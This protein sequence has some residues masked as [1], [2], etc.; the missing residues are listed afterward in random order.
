MGKKALRETRKVGKALREARISGRAD[1]SDFKRQILELRAKVRSSLL[2]NDLLAMP[3]IPEKRIIKRNCKG[4][5]VCCLED[6]G[7]VMLFPDDIE[8]IE[9]RVANSIGLRTV[10]EKRCEVDKLTGNGVEIDRMKWKG[11]CAFLEPSGNCKIYDDRPLECKAFP[12]L[13]MPITGPY[14][15]KHETPYTMITKTETDTAI[16]MIANTEIRNAMSNIAEFM[17]G[18]GC[19]VDSPRTTIVSGMSGHLWAYLN[20][21]A[22][23]LMACAMRLFT[24]PECVEPAYEIAKRIAAKNPTPEPH[25]LGAYRDMLADAIRYTQ[26]L[27]WPSMECVTIRPEA[28]GWRQI[29]KDPPNF[30]YP[31]LGVTLEFAPEDGTPAEVEYLMNHVLE[32][33]VSAGLV[34]TETTEE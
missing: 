24:W 6:R 12:L 31:R 33:M 28:G 30:V 20:P 1:V 26:D 8:R 27:K 25:A 4:C 23:M 17:P 9:A 16:L 7:E 2:L 5:G 29:R 13:S 14:P 18:M 34:D 21:V 11:R 3:F 19:R 10:W 15:G 22:S 32:A